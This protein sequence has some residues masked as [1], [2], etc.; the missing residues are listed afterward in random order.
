[1]SKRSAKFISAFFAS[2]L[3][4]TSFAA[5]AQDAA[6]ENS[7]NKENSAKTA[8]TCLTRPKGPLPAGG[9]WYYRTDHATKRN[10][11]YIGEGKNKTARAAPKESSSTP[12]A[13]DSASAEA[14]NAVS[15][16]QSIN[17]RK[18]IANARAE[19]TAPQAR[20]EDLIEPQSTG[21]VPAA[22]IANSQIAAA[23]D[24]PPPSSVASRWP[25][26]SGVSPSSGPRLAA[27]EPSQSLQTQ[28]PQTQSLQ[29][30]NLQTQ[31]LQTNPTAAPQPAVPPVALAAADTSQERRSAS[32]QMLLLVMAGALALAGISASLVYRFGRAQAVPLEA[33]GDRRAIWDSIPTERTSPSM[34]PDE[35]PI[36][37]SNTPRDV[38]RDPRAPDDPER[39]VTEMLARLA[40]SAHT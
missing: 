34:F 37:R 28:N 14:A 27:A 18:A 26:S 7:A 6:K 5:V 16:Q 23:P 25:E 36:W 2:I 13:S 19:L 32:M 10:C 22:R 1:M 38:P 12:A 8:D 29:T 31:S 39:R 21:A 20:V 4:G 17:A 35:T 3:A 40:R 24:S 33:R 9:H 15:P 11:W 30:Q